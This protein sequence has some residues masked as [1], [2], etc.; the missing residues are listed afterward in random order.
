[1]RA[2]RIPRAA[3]WTSTASPARSARLPTSAPTSS[4]RPP[5]LTS[6]APEE[7]GDSSAT[8]DGGINPGGATT[9]WYFNYGTTGSYGLKTTVQVLPPT[10]STQSVGVPVSGL[11]PG[12]LYHFQLVA[13]NVIG[14]TSGADGTFVTAPSP[15]MLTS[16]PRD[17]ALHLSSRRFR[18]ATH[19][20]TVTSTR[21]PTGTTVSYS[22]SQPATTS[23]TVLEPASGVRSGHAL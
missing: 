10:F 17:S 21:P 20:A 2:G 23:L 6:S 7:V 11:T 8:L 14:A 4:T 3:R 1:M 19:G 16:A 9:S 18:A 5:P 13:A 22:D 15:A 12:T